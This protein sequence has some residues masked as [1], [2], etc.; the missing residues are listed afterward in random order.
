MSKKIK[1]VLLMLVS[2]L[3]FA[4]MQVTVGE[5]GG[6][7]PI[8]QQLF[9]RNLVAAAVAYVAIRKNKLP[10]LGKK[11]NRSIL[12]MRSV[13]GY[14]GMVAL[15]YAS[16][17]GDQG[18]VA[19]ISKMS[20]FIISILAYFILK[21]EITK[22]QITGL[23]VAFVGAYFVSNPQY[24][25]NSA[26]IIAAFICCILTGI[27]YT[28]V[29]ALKGREEPPVIIFFFSAFSTLCSL[30]FMIATWAVPSLT[31]FLLLLCIGASAAVGQ[32]KIGR[33]H[34]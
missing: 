18:D 34:V 29:S 1:A 7:V 23:F 32:V 22:Y 12:I 27:S 19:T 8:F 25:S 26:P 31:D 21:E 3:A 11:G 20:P 5:T 28:C 33:A 6:R 30:P 15:F 24:N 2:A 9:F 13:A 14:L 10:S 16:A 4:I 17:N